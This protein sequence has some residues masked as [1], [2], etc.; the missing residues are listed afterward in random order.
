MSN[1]KIIKLTSENTKRLRAVEIV[2]DKDGHLVVISGR[3]GQGKSSVLDSIAM[4]LAGGDAIPPMPVRKGADK[5][6]TVVEL[7]DLI[8]TRTFTAAGGTSLK[9]TTRDGKPQLSPQAILDRLVGKLTFDPLDFARRGETAEGRRWQADTLRKLA[10]LDFTKDDQEKAKAETERTAIGR[11]RDSFKNQR[12]AC[13][14]IKDAPKEEVSGAAILAEQQKASETNTANEKARQALASS[15]KVHTDGKALAAETKAKIVRLKEELRQQENQL[16]A[17]RESLLNGETVLIEMRQQV[18]A[19]EDLDLEQ[20][21]TK[22]ALVEDANKKVRQNKQHA[23]LEAKHKAK[24]KAYD[25]LTRKIETIEEKK[26]T[27]IE[28]AKMP[29]PG[30]AFTQLGGVSLNGIPFEQTSSAEQLRVSVAIGLCLN[31]TLKVLLIRDGSL[32]DDEAMLALAEMAK[33]ADA[34]VWIERVSDDSKTAV[35]IED[36]QVVEEAPE[37]QQKEL[38]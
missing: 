22:L 26:R 21:K 38:V 20:F 30:L 23:D 6:K 36:G 28:S 15:E 35:I 33:A 19:L 27:A 10:S 16:K 7:D 11:D 4:A 2:P 9:V 13:P 37:P 5:A 17:I 34:Q 31:P 1:S 8:V 25:D 18:A 12:D 32:L 3:N 24:A 14:A 29:V